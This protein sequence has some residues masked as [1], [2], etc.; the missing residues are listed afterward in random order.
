MHDPSF[1]S[2]C[3]EAESFCRHKR[4]ESARRLVVEKLGLDR[5]TGGT[6]SGFY[7][8]FFLVVD[9]SELHPLM[10]LTF[11][12]PY[13]LHVNVH[14]YRR[15]NRTN[16][17]SILGSHIMNNDVGCYSFRATQWLLSS[18]TEEDLY[19]ILERCHADAQKG[20][21]ALSPCLFCQS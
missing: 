13:P 19:R 9:F 4:V 15:L 7:K 17:S 3:P 11:S 2:A 21:A 1:T 14:T 6:Y 16:Q 10:V 18:L 20:F 12:R 8:D 5:E